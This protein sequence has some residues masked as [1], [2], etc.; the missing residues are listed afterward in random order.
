MHPYFY[1]PSKNILGS[2]RHRKRMSCVLFSFL[3]NLTARRFAIICAKR[4][5]LTFEAPAASIKPVDILF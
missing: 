1:I 4:Y 5:N 2:R 3:H